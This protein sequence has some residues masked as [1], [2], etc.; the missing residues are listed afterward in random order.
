[1]S[2]NST[3]KQHSQ[4]EAVALSDEQ[5]D[6]IAGG[7]STAYSPITERNNMSEGGVMSAPIGSPL[8]D[9]SQTSAV[10][11]WTTARPGR[12]SPKDST[13]PGA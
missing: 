11:N 3:R 1:M 5:L 13:T 10:S 2:D 7:V 12:L 6:T 4:S 9:P 8:P